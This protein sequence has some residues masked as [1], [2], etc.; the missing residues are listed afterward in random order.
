MMQ[1]SEMEMVNTQQL[2]CMQNY[3]TCRDYTVNSTI[4]YTF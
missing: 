4:N 1:G 3:I 2:H